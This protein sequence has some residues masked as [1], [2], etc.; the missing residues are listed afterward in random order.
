MKK[1]LI[2]AGTITGVCVLALVVVAFSLGS[3]ITRGVNSYG[4]K[5]TNTRVSLSNADISPFSGSGTLRGF[6]VGNPAGWS[7]A[8]LASF[9]KIHVSVVPSS[10]RGDHIIINEIDVEA[11][12]FDYETKLVSSNVN[13]LLA[14]IE[15]AGGGSSAPKATAKNG[16]PLRIEVKH[17][18]VHDGVVRLGA[19]KAAVRIPLPPIEL[20]DIGTRE[21]G[22]TPDQ[23]ATVVMKSVTSNIV[24]ATTQA[25]LKVGGTA[26]AA[27]TEGVKKAGGAIKGL[28]GGKK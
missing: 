13:D 20:S 15:K 24:H 27:A 17:F 1:L 22:V 18:R 10:I 14:N 7:D 8:D 2:I 28:F 11:P 3:I 12:L 19:G 6:K 16:K 4:P 5:L 21:N 25:A 9:G 23:L 26:G